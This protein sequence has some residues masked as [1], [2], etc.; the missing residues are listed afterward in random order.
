MATNLRL[1]PE[2]ALALQAE[3]E[4]TGRSQQDILREAVDRHL[5]LVQDERVTSDRERAWTAQVV[6]PARVPY[7]KVT[8]TLRL[9]EGMNSLDLLDRNDRF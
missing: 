8:P 1:S 2:A 7:R 3:S 4:R 9:P 6:R 5:H